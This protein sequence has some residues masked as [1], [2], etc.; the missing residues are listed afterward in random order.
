MSET[1]HTEGTA[2]GTSGVAAPATTE[3]AI[4]QLEERKY[5]EGFVTDVEQ[6]SCWSS[7]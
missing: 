3:D 5:R 1:D 4:R 2:P 7:G 6:D